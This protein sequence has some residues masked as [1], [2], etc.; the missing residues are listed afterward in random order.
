MKWG[1]NMSLIQEREVGE[2][3][4]VASRK[5]RAG[6]SKVEFS[7]FLNGWGKETYNYVLPWVPEVLHPPPPQLWM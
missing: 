1:K 7:S 4:T 5:L 2:K 6:I 3:Y